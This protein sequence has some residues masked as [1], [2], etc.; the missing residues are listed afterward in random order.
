M[1]K[2]LT[3]VPCTVGCD[4]DA[5]LGTRTD[6]M[7]ATGV[8]LA[9]AEVRVRA[10]SSADL[11]FVTRTGA[12]GVARPIISLKGVPNVVSAWACAR[13]R[14]T[15]GRGSVRVGGACGAQAEAKDDAVAACSASGAS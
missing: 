9:V 10:R 15:R 12:V 8:A 4:V 6:P 13:G 7:P 1:A 14:D 5:N 3:F 11:A 2:G